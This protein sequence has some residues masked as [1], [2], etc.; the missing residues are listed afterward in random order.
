MKAPLN[1]TLEYESGFIG[2]KSVFCPNSTVPHTMECDGVSKSIPIRCN[3][4]KVP[5]GAC[6]IFSHL[7]PWSDDSCVVV[8]TN[9]DNVTCECDIIENVI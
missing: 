9:D 4:I 6:T 2:K 3:E 8:A 5:R 1:V 7:G